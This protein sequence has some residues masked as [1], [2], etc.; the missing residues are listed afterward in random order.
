METKSSASKKSL[1]GSLE[2]KSSGKGLLNLNL[3][4]YSS[5]VDL[6]DATVPLERQG[7][8]HG[9]I[10]R[11]EAESTL[12]SLNEGRAA[13]VVVVLEV[14]TPLDVLVV[15]AEFGLVRGD[16]AGVVREAKVVLGAAADVANGDFVAVE[17]DVNGLRVDARGEDLDVTGDFVVAEAAG[18]DF[19]RV[20][21]VDGGFT[22]ETLPAAAVVV[23]FVAKVVL[24]VAEVGDAL[25]PNGGFVVRGLAFGSSF[26]ELST[27]L[28]AAF[29][30][31]SGSSLGVSLAAAAAAAAV[32]AATVTAAPATATPAV[33]AGRTESTSFSVFVI[34]S[35]SGS[36]NFSTAS[37][38][39]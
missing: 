9:A 37:M 32:A 24:G 8:Y 5:G 31:T 12:R 21:S 1:G 4:A 7:W 23:V 34:S 2:L 11:V 20:L 19:G 14:A 18:L 39:F 3:G 35:A 17:G 28:V 38:S 26:F 25:A 16:L 10:S 30:L 27:G 6:I 22:G 29:F 13:V 36:A 15:V 33:T